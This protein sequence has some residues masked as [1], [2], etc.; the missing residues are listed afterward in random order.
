V[1]HTVVVHGARTRYERAGTGPGLE[2]LH[3]GG[4]DSARLTWAALRRS[5]RMVRRTL[6]SLR[7][8]AADQGVESWEVTR[9]FAP[10]RARRWPGWG[11]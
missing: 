9:A 4:L 10:P 7:V 1:E 5:R 2:L 3:G 8:K 11:R 6:G